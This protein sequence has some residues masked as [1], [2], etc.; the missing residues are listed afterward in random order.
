MLIFQF[1]IMIKA[2]CLRVNF[3]IDW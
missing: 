1:D 3:V 2:T